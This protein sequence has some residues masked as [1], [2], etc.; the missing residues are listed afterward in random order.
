MDPRIPTLEA[1]T[2]RTGRALDELSRRVDD[3]FRELRSEMREQGKEL[4]SDIRDTRTESNDRY[5]ELRETTRWLIGIQ[6]ATLLSVVGLLAKAA[7][8]F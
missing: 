8:L 6:V 3:G 5:K 4:R 2:E 7:N 1:I